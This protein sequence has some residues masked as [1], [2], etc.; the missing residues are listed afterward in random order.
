M[1]ESDFLINQRR[2]CKL[3]IFKSRHLFF[4]YCILEL[5][6][7]STCK[8]QRGGTRNPRIVAKS[9]KCYSHCCGGWVRLTRLY[10]NK[11]PGCMWLQTPSR[12]SRLLTIVLPLE[13]PALL[14]VVM[15]TQGSTLTLT[16]SLM[17][18]KLS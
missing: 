7:T 17:E 8:T 6:S 14:K 4:C 15:D 1:F 5:V 10:L 12:L 9:R 3:F 18:S 2:E 16:C 13:C 11:V